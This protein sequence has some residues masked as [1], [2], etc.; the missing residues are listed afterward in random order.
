MSAR[1][2]LLV[3]LCNPGREYAPTRHNAGAW[4]VER[5]A[6][7]AGATFEREPKFHAYMA[8]QATSAGEL[9]ILVPRTYMNES[10][11]AV[12]G[13]ARFFRIAP[14]E[15]AIAHDELDLKP[16]MVKL[17]RGG[18]NAGHNGLRD[19]VEKLGSG[20]FWR[21]RIGIGHPRDTALIAHDVVDYVLHPP[22]REEQA[23]IDDAIARALAVW[24]FL[25][26]GDAER[27]MH[28]LHTRARATPAESGKD[29]SP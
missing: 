12:G 6:D 29:A 18:G 10:G 9:R 19:V 16:G 24:P 26:D 23:S 13:A 2:K 21:I 20:D 8:R 27:A 7:D 1:I 3:G 11:L 4:F 14:E 17:K 15:I 5:V 22:R 28:E 25:R